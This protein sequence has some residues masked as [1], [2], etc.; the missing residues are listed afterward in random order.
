[1]ATPRAKRNNT[2][3]DTVATNVDPRKQKLVLLNESHLKKLR[4][5]AFDTGKSES[6]IV[7]DSLDKYLTDI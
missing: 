1:M 5:L 2:G 6:E 3:I 4:Q 7:R